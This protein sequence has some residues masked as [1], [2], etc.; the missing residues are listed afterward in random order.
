MALPTTDA[1][2][3]RERRTAATVAAVWV[4]GALSAWSGLDRSLAAAS[5]R[6]L[7]PPRPSVA[8]LA[9]RVGPGDPRPEWYAAALALRA[10][11]ELAGSGP[12]TIDPN[13]AGRAEWD[14]L[15]GIGPVTAIAIVEHRGIHGPFRGPDDLL[16]VRGI[17]PR[18]LEKLRPFLAW[19]TGG[20]GED[21]NYASIARSS[22]LPDLNAVDAAF[23][24]ALP[25]FGPKLAK[26]ILRERQARGMFRQWTELVSIDG[27]GPARLR[28]LQ[29]ATRLRG[30]SAQG[31]GD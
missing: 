8:E 30:T 9:A 4:A 5:D 12:A 25:G 17:G 28:V 7:H 29:K 2:T 27:V 6:L 11:E 23:L 1:W 14:R 19:E 31:E 26:T 13:A 21:P 24:A 22:G 18:T 16:E 20:S 15:P 3:P 10:E